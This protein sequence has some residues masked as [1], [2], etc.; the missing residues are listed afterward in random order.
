MSRLLHFLFAPPHWVGKLGRNGLVAATCLLLLTL[1][2]APAAQADPD[3]PLTAQSETVIIGASATPPILDGKCSTFANEYLDAAVRSF[4]T[5]Y[6]ATV[7]VKHTDTDLWVCMSGMA[8]PA[9]QTQTGPNAAVYIHRLDASPT[10]PDSDTFSASISFSGQGGAQRGSRTGYMDYTL[11]GWDAARYVYSGDVPTWDAEFRLS[12]TFL[13]DGVW[14]RDIRIGF[15]QQWINYAGDDYSWPSG[16][17]PSDQFS[18]LSPSTWAVG[19]LTS[20]T[21]SSTLDLAATR[22]EVTQ[23]IQDPRLN[24]VPLIA[25]K[26]TFVRVYAVSNE[27]GYRS[28]AVSARLSGRRGGTSLGTLLPLNPG[29]TIAVPMRTNPVV[30]NR[31]F[32][33]EL[34][35]TWTAAGTL[36]LSATVNP[37]RNPAELT[38]GNNDIAR[39]VLFSQ[40][41][42]LALM[43]RNIGY[44]P[45][46]AP[47]TVVRADSFHLDMLESWL[48]R[49]FPINRLDSIRRDLTWIGPSPL[50]TDILDKGD[51]VRDW[52]RVNRLLEGNPQRIQVGIVTDAGGFM[53]GK[54]WVPAN[55][56]AT[57][58]GSNSYGWDFD[59][60]YTDWYGAEMIAHA[61]GRP[62]AGR[63]FGGD[64]G[65][66]A[67]WY[68]WDEPFPYDHS[69]IGGPEDLPWTFFGF[70][71][72][73]PG[74]GLPPAVVSPT[75]T[76]L[77]SHCP[78]RWVSD[79]TYIRL[80]RDINN[81][82]GPHMAAAASQS[83]GDWL[84]VAGTIDSLGPT[85]HFNIVTREPSVQEIPT[86]TPGPY[87]LRLLNAAGATLFD[88]PFTP[89]T[90]TEQINL[91]SF[92][93]AIEFQPGTS[94]LAV[95]DSRTGVTLVEHTVSPNPPQVT[96]VTQDGGPSLGV[97]GPVRVTWNGVDPDPGDT[98]LTYSLRYS[99][100][101][102]VNWRTL[103]VGASETSFVV[104]AGELE[105]TGGA[106]TGMF[107][108]IASDG[109]NTGRVES[110]PFAVAG[111]APT[112]RIAAPG[113][114]SSYSFGQTLAF[115]AAA[116]DFE[117]GTLPDAAV[118]WT[119]SIDGELGYGLLHH[120]SLL[121]PGVHTITVTA[122]D[123]EG[124][125]TSSS[126][127][128]TILADASLAAIST[129]TLDVAPG[130]LLFL[131]RAGGPQPQ[132]LTLLINNLAGGPLAWQA[133]ANL[134]WLHLDPM[135]GDDEGEVQVTA[136]SSGL[137]PGD[138]VTGIITIT[139]PGAGASPLTI[140]V[141]LQMQSDTRQPSDHQL[142][143]PN[144]S[145]YQ[146]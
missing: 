114:G 90:D 59:G 80:Q 50:S 49:A 98:E 14:N 143:L 48:R 70:D 20:R 115:Q 72:G 79:F 3:L 39:D 83:V 92:M 29:G 37:V 24:S 145:A 125:A 15:A 141:T 93:L 139:S 54:A 77:M 105:G 102:G 33:F 64:I 57:P 13:G 63:L 23:A 25:G 88:Q 78:N 94:R 58:A 76:D 30:L 100:D 111:K 123:S 119:S 2:L 138:M 118:R 21:T 38:F 97:S 75:A 8:Y 120:E 11:G 130:N 86:T 34:P 74:L 134:P 104:D 19:R 1:W 99:F 132:G 96:N 36:S 32:L 40:T 112:L 121:S 12:R 43:L 52:I 109:A 16:S 45:G 101:S 47:G 44:S 84:V 87:S 126:I 136:D 66:G 107:Q 35:S 31:S 60:S 140:P 113:N 110:T 5:P 53:R 124:Q 68:G 18:Y 137:R 7:Y 65:C 17:P 91:F 73:D 135:A 89:I 56:V 9:P 108:I 133:S 27:G 62:H 146:P 61:L 85:A 26:R 46:S 71:A 4:R 28:N 103:M 131:A 142:Y 122:T 128:L 42:P 81:R 67:D 22:L 117:D 106:A 10:A 129:P 55:E 41:E 116:E 6:I 127:T 69:R 82:F 144:I 51:F 95:V